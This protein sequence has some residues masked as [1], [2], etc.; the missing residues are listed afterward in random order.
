MKRKVRPA[1]VGGS[2]GKRK[3]AIAGRFG[4][5]VCGWCEGVIGGYVIYCQMGVELC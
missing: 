3:G 4:G 2:E 1:G 5:Y